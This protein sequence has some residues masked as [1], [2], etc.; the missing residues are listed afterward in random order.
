MSL[1]TSNQ[2]NL[3]FNTQ[4]SSIKSVNT[5]SSNGKSTDL[6]C[7]VENLVTSTNGPNKLT[8]TPIDDMTLMTILLRAKSVN[9][10]VNLTCTLKAVLPDTLEEIP[11]YLLDDVISLTL[12]T[13]V[14]ENE[15]TRFNRT[16]TTDRKIILVKGITYQVTITSDS[17]SA[18]A[19]AYAVLVVNSKRRSL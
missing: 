9:A 4:V 11:K 18:V 19:R 6:L 8:F 1:L 2:I 14:G 12:T 13:I 5:I 17:A 16:L 7:D 3:D 10:G 15:A